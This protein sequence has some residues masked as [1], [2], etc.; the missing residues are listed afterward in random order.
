MLSRLRE[1]VT[2]WFSQEHRTDLLSAYGTNTLTL[3]NIYLEFIQIVN[4]LIDLDSVP[5]QK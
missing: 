1:V 5:N 3:P 2:N 4:N